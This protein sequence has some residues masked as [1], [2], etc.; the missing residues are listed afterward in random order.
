MAAMLEQLELEEGMRVLE[1]GAGTG[2]NAALLSSLVGPS[3]SVVSVDIDREVAVQARRSL[4][5]GGFRVHV[6]RAD[7]R[8]GHTRAAPYHRIIVTAST[9]TVP[10]AWF[11]QLV[12]GGRLEAP[13]RLNAAGPQVIAA[14]RRAPLGFR[15]VRAVSG[16]FMPLR[17]ENDA[18]VPPVEPYLL[19]SHLSGGRPGVLLHL[20]GGALA[21][22]SRAAE[23]QLLVTAL[24]EPRRQRLELRGSHAALALFVSLR[25]P[26][27]RL[28]TT[29]LG[30][31]GV[32]AISRDGRS[33]ALIEARPDRRERGILTAYGGADA[34]ELVLERIRDWER[35]GCPSEADLRVDVTYDG[36]RPRLTVRWPR[37]R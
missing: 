22:L 5:N 34:E 3:G 29:S 37:V 16:G 15:S 1:I 32:G 12:D 19:V 30:R 23:R 33:L 9:D 24:G 25:L 11:E 18:G 28:V 20:N 27:S 4:H 8:H 21:T 14:L 13:L 36:D 7:G 6:A 31:F 35:R 2:Y 17:D 10:R 26:R